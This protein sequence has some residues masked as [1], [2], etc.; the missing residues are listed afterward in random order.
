MNR[1]TAEC[2]FWLAIM[3]MVIAFYYFDY[4]KAEAQVKVQQLEQALQAYGTK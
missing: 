1:H 4:K 2:I 3:G